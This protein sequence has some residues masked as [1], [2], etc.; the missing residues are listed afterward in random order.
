[1]LINARMICDDITRHVLYLFYRVKTLF[2]ACNFLFFFG[3]KQRIKVSSLKYQR[4]KT[5]IKNGNTLMWQKTAKGRK[6]YSNR[7]FF[8]DSLTC[9]F[10]FEI[11][12]MME[13]ICSFLPYSSILFIVA[14]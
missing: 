4:S 5:N 2:L 8:F 14:F 11:G 12:E 9:L 3:L 10:V 1:M 13:R 6:Y 7:N